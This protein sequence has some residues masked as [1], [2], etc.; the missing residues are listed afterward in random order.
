MVYDKKFWNERYKKDDY[1]YG[2]EPSSFLVE[3]SNL[4]KGSVLSLSEG[5]GRNAVYLAS[6]GLKVCGVDISG[7]ALTKAHALAK[8]HNVQIE[9][10]IA[11][12]SNFEPKENYYD[13]VISICAHLPSVVRD[14][15]YPLVEKCLKSN[16]VILLEAYSEQQLKRT[17]GG[18]NDIDMLMSISK[19]K[20]EFPNLEPI[21]LRELERDE[22]ELGIVS[23]V[24]FIARK[25]T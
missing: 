23:I 20:K 4:L 19:I 2:I 21:V 5:E 1:L 22:G 15:L 6:R 14:H 10:K 12:L 11:D 8:I 13:S 17:T 9:T 16:G 25:K 24:Q 7:V 3:Y 18:P